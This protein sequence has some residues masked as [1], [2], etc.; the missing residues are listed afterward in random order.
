LECCSL[1]CA[2][3][4]ILSLYLGHRI[5]DHHMK[6]SYKGTL[7]CTL[8]T[9]FGVTE[10]PGRERWENA[11]ACPCLRGAHGGHSPTTAQ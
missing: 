6:K 7:Y 4:N 2:S 9:V 1:R 10:S 3:L 8:Q 11:R 5:P